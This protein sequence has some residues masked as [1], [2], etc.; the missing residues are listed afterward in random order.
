M[1]EITTKITKDTKDFDNKSSNFV[2]FAFFV[3]KH[4]AADVPNSRQ[5]NVHPSSRR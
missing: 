3:V 1:H 2:L 5:S 4:A